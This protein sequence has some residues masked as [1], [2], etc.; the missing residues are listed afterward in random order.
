VTDEAVI[1]Q[2]AG[3][4]GLTADV[5]LTGPKHRVLAQLNQSDLAFLRDRARAVEAELW[6][7]G[8]TLWARTRASRTT[9]ETA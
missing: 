2:I 4:H 1:R 9:G 6:M 5:A 8:S 3:E 7:D